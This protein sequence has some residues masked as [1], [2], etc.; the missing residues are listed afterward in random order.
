MQLKQAWPSLRYVESCPASSSGCGAESEQQIAGG[1]QLIGADGPN[2]AGKFEARMESA[3][4]VTVGLAPAAGIM[5]HR[6]GRGRRLSLTMLHEA[7]L[8]VDCFIRDLAEELVR[9]GPPLRWWHAWTR[10]DYTQSGE[11]WVRRT[12]GVCSITVPFDYKLIAITI[13]GQRSQ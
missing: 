13:S 9:D 1:E 6:R 5:S 4:E 8:N 3:V 11:R 10:L 7:K 2:G 12:W